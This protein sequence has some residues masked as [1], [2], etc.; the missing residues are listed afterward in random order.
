[1][2][3]DDGSITLGERLGNIEQGIH[4]IDV[5]LD[6]KVDVEAHEQLVR[7]V[8][9]LESGD[10]PLARILTEQF[11]ATQTTV[12]DLVAHGSANAQETAKVSAALRVDVTELQKAREADR[13]VLESN[14]DRL[15]R[16]LRWG[17]LMV[18]AVAAS[19]WIITLVAH[20]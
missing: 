1:M 3:L 12:S 9:N 10:T 11:R 5:K 13:A 20:P 8:E 6:R 4:R 7:R 17:T 15:L 19:G 14:Q 18:S 2:P 16:T